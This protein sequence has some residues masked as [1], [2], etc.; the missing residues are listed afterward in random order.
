MDSCVPFNGTSISHSTT[1]YV[2]SAKHSQYFIV[3]YKLFLEQPGSG[4]VNCINN[5]NPTGKIPVGFGSY[6][7]N[8][9]SSLILPSTNLEIVSEYAP[10]L[11]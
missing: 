1:P 4:A 8:Y 7:I 5:R 3:Y 9:T 11:V 6:K 2:I 10:L